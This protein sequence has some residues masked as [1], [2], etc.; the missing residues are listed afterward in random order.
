[1]TEKAH[2]F[3]V[4]AYYYF[5]T[6]EDPHLEVSRH[7]AFVQDK[8]IYCRVYLS[9]EGIN[10]QMSASL[11][12]SQIYQEWIK[13]DPRF[14]DI[15]FKIH[16]H[17]EHV[18][19]RTTVKFRKQ[20]VAIDEKVDM[21]L[22]GERVS[23]EKW[24]EMLQRRDEK[25]L[26]LDVRNDYEWEIGHFEGAEL[27]KLE[28][29]RQFPNYARQLKESCDPKE[30]KVMMYCTGGIRCELY[31]ALLKKEGF[32]QV[33]QLEGGI[34]NYGLK[35]GHDLWR[36]K[37]FVFDDRLAVPVDEKTEEIISE[38]RHCK[39]ASDVYYNCANMDCNELFLSCSECAEKLKGCCCKQCTQTSRL[40]PY[41]QKDR[42]KPFRR[43][44]YYDQCTQE[45][46]HP[47]ET[48][49]ECSPL[50]DD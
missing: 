47:L 11:E 49:S 37:L 30:T 24:K 31:S 32:N 40:R 20:L 23:P 45:Q 26:L 39:T 41:V 8:D 18:F 10:G 42:P 15:V 2:H 34:I 35:E 14:K 4:L 3:Q 33:Y 22:T 6:I 19:P 1:M 38:C 36:G 43:A 29:F 48:F 7:L 25:T 44:H 12:A 13:S 46:L 9:H 28:S 50:T 17:T 27:P 16:T 21:S 5:T